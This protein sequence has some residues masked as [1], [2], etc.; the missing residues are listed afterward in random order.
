MGYV[1]IVNLQF[2]LF[3][4]TWTFVAIL[5]ITV[6]EAKL[7]PMQKSSIFWVYLI[8]IDID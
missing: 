8:I 6:N 3:T 1:Q 7:Y 4:C 5:Y 2:D